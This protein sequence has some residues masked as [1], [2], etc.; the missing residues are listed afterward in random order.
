MQ[1]AI[2]NCPK[3]TIG[4]NT[5]LGVAVR[6]YLEPPTKVGPVMQEILYDRVI[7]FSPRRPAQQ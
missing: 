6:T 5:V 1:L 3:V 2:D 4:P 7:K